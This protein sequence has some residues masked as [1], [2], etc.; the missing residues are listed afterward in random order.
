MLTDGLS[1]HSFNGSYKVVSEDMTS[2]ITSIT[3]DTPLDKSTLHH[4]QLRVRNF[5]VSGSVALAGVCRYSAGFEDDC[6]D[7][8]DNDCNG[9]T[10][11]EDPACQ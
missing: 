9:L 10:D 3:P 8:L 2:Y 1:L 5:G 11:A 6:T 7:G 4:I